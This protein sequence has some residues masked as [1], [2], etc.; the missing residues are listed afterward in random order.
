ML[1]D[2]SFRGQQ[3]NHR[4][5]LGMCR[6]SAAKT[7]SWGQYGGREGGRGRRT[8]AGCRKSNRKRK[9][10][11]ERKKK[12]PETSFPKR[13]YIKKSK[14]DNQTEVNSK[15]RERKKKK[16]QQKKNNRGDL[17]I[18]QTLELDFLF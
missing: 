18:K 12:T 1:L 15:R 13:K 14:Q 17:T 4:S 2:L 11:E 8:D 5:N 9:E 6:L 3:E 10:K 16:A 7:A